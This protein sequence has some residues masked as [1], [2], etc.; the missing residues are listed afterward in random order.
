MEYIIDNTRI[1]ETHCKH[2]MNDMRIKNSI[3]AYAKERIFIQYENK[4]KHIYI[5]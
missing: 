1:I 5:K 4:I 3:K 2:L